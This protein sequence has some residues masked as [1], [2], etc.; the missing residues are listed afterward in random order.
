MTDKHEVS[1]MNP[2]TISL[3]LGT[4]LS[5]FLLAGATTIELLGAGEAPGI[6]IL[7]VFVGIIA[8]LLAGGVVSVSADRLSGIAA[9]AL[10]AYATFGVAFVTIAGIR[11]VNVPFADDV[12]TFA[13]QIGVSV[14][15]AVAVA[16]L[17]RH[18][19]SGRLTESA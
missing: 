14:V 8:G 15:L 17:T 9:S 19:R 13:V 1:L 3:G 7:G 10:V 11:Y 6:G 18:K 12:F 4:A 16:L 2:R 5:T